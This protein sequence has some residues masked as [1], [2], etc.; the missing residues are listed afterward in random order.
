MVRWL[1]PL[2]AVTVEPARRES[3]IG[4]GRKRK[5]RLIASFFAWIVEQ[6]VYC[7][8]ELLNQL[9]TERILKDF[10]SG[11][12]PSDMKLKKPSGFLF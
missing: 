8:V 11:T 3:W 10:K 12:Q 9:G 7:Q 4:V 2:N 1:T 6:C 5:R